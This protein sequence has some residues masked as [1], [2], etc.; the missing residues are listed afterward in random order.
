MPGSALRWSRRLRE[1]LAPGAVPLVLGGDHSL[2][3][4][5]MR[6]L[7]ERYG[8]DGYAVLHLDT[9]ADTAASLYGVRLSHGTPFRVTVE[10]GVL[11]ASQI[12]PGGPARN[13]AGTRGLRLDAGR[14]VSLAHDGRDLARGTSLR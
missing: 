8:A 13:V 12:R 2:S 6:V 5:T 14:G 1:I 9:H 11:R 10:D 4:P 3:L 7:A